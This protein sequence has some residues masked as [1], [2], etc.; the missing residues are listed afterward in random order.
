M[1]YSIHLKKWEM[2][3]IEWN[4]LLSK[5]VNVNPV[6]LLS[7]LPDCDNHYTFMTILLASLGEIILS[8][9]ASQ[10]FLSLVDY[11]AHSS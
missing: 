9:C 2:R 8:H 10:P 6:L 4:A 1:R 5:A 7:N 11:T 3:P